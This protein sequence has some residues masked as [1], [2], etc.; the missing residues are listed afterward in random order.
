MYSLFDLLAVLPSFFVQFDIKGPFKMMSQKSKSMDLI[1]DFILHIQREKLVPSNIGGQ[2]I[3]AFNKLAM[4]LATD[5]QVL[6]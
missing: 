4:D 6:N 3:E 1:N 5:G 2:L